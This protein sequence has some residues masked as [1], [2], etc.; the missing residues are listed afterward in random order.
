MKNKSFIYD[1]II[2]AS[3]SHMNRALICA[4]YAKNIKLI[5]DSKCDDVVKM[6]E[7]FL[8]IDPSNKN[9]VFDCGAAGTV[10]RF[11][12]LRVSRI[13]GKHVLKG[14]ERLMSR[15]QEELEAIF[16][17]IGI[18]MIKNSDSIVIEGDGWKPIHST[19]IINR[20]ISSQFASGVLLNAWDLPYDLSLKFEGESVSEG[21]WQL[22]KQVVSDFGMEFILD[23]DQETVVKRSSK[24][25][26]STYEVESDL[27][28]AF[29]IA[30]FAALNGEA[31]FR[32][33]PINSLQPDIAFIE[34]LTKMG[35]PLSY[36]QDEKYLKISKAETLI[37]IH[38]NL[39][40]C[41]DLFPVL[42]TLCAFAI[43]KSILDGAP[44]LIYKESNRIDKS[45][46]LIHFLNATTEKLP[47][48]M[49]IH[50][51]IK[52]WELL[53]AQKLWD[54]DTDHDHR[55]A[56]AAALLESQGLPIK[57]LHPE[58]VN[59]SFPEFWEIIK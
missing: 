41:P 15:P 10:L 45:A 5:G 16:N 26:I 36:N 52:N 54:Y 19:I 49:V 34:V 17:Q 39:L 42:S 37:P 1:G 8:Q 6:K 50:S 31:H 56:F 23:N 30:A 58:V 44:H 20:H 7:A 13:P 3:K 33:F 14:T 28:S 29:A 9:Q 4:S 21:Y 35:V 48:G 40:N 27:S 57:I 38:F 11:L 46:E 2:P 47:D 12:A 53:K 55:L 25:N 59:K 43:G 22:T 32:N 51:Q 24:T 18:T